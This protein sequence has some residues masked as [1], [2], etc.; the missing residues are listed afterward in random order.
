MQ[1]LHTTELNLGAI[2]RLETQAGKGRRE[3]GFRIVVN[4]PNEDGTTTEVTMPV[5]PEEARLLLRLAGKEH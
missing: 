4:R 2:A 5:T 3:Q 1:T